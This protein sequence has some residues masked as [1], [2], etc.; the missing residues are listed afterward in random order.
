MEIFKE[1]P[2]DMSNYIEIHVDDR[3]F[4]AKAALNTPKK[5]RRYSD[6]FKDPVY[7][8]KENI[9]KL[10]MMRKFKLENGNLDEITGKWKNCI[11][12]CMIVLIDE[13]EMGVKDI[14]EAFKLKKYGFDTSE[15]GDETDFEEDESDEEGKWVDE[16]KD[17]VE[18]SDENK[19]TAKA[20]NR[21]YYED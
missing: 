15:Y 2:E 3:I 12:E 9:R 5:Q 16:D 6:Q 17:R 8:Q 21:H 18:E 19:E 13:Y 20:A 14:F 4:Y 7:E 10:K 1:K 11:H